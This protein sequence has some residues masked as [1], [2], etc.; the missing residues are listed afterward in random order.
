MKVLAIDT[1][2]SPASAALVENQKIIGEFFINTKL[3]HSQTIMPMVE[4]LLN[5]CETKLEDVDVLAVSAGPGSFTGIRIGIAAIKGMA[6]GAEK[7]CVPVSTLEAMAYCHL[8]HNGIVCSVMD[9]R[10]NQVYNGLFR[11]EN[12]KVI[13]LCPDRAISID[14]LIKELEN[15]HE[16]II[17]VGDGAELCN[18][19]MAQTSVCAQLAPFNVRFQNASAVAFAAEIQAL[20]GKTISSKELMP[21]YLRLPQA[22]R[23]LKKKQGAKNS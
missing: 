13:R 2:A 9:A 11:V 15:V 6:Y 22:E 1:S 23:E 3:T 10:C 18:K 19:A 12:G 16:N 8:Y 17:L 14:D 7:K 20:E 5:C 21:V 4:S